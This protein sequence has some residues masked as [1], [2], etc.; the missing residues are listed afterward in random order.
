MSDPGSSTTEAKSGPIGPDLAV[1]GMQL[2][3]RVRSREYLLRSAF[4]GDKTLGKRLNVVYNSGDSWT[5]VSR[6]GSI[7]ARESSARAA[8]RGDL[9]FSREMQE[10]CSWAS[11]LIRWTSKAA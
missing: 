8:Q 9:G 11:T 7:T 2:K 1:C 4:S 3:K 6:S 5:H 10:R